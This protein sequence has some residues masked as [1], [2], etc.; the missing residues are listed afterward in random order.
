MICQERMFENF[1]K[2]IGSEGRAGRAGAAKRAWNR[3]GLGEAP[4]SSSRAA[5]PAEP[6][7]VCREGHFSNIRS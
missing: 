1:G 4:P 7:T 3:P 6:G 2:R 5:A